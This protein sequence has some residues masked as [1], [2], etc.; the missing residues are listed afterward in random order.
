MDIGAWLRGLGLRQYEQMFREHGVDLE[1]LPYLTLDDL[2]DMGV[3]AVGH[4]RKLLQAAGP[5]RVMPDNPQMPTSAAPEQPTKLAAER[6]Q[7]TVA[8]FDLVGSTALSRRLD[9][10]DMREIIRAYQNATA[11]EI[12]RFGG[13]VAK[14]MGDGVLAYFGWPQAQEDAAERAVR[15]ALGV[16]Q[17][18][19]R[20]A[21]PVEEPLIPRI[22]IATGV[23]VV[24]DLVG[25]GAAQEEAVVGETP[26]LAARLQQVAE[27]GTVV[28]GDAT[29]RLLGDLFVVERLPSPMLRGFDDSVHAYRVLGEGGAESRFEAMHGA[30]P[31]PLIGREPEL[32]LLLERWQLATAGEGQVVLLGGE[33]GIGKSRLVLA[34]RER[35][36][37][38]NR[39]R[40]SYA[41]SPHHTNSVLWPVT[42]QLERAARFSRD[43]R[44]AE[45][46][47]KLRSLLA[48][49]AEATEEMVTLLAELLGMPGNGELPFLNLTPQVRKARTLTVLMTQLEGLAER[50]PVLLILEDSHWLDPTTRELFDLVVDRIRRL[51]VLLVVTFRPELEPPWTGFAHVT[52]LTLNRLARDQAE[53]LVTHVAGGRHLPAEVVNAILARTEGMPLF[54]EELTKTVLEAG[55]LAETADGL[56]LAGPLPSLA[57]PAS[58]NDSL[59]ARLDRLL[60]VKQVAQTAA[61][62]GRD[63]GHALLAAVAGLSARHLQDALE[64]LVRAELVF[65][66]GTSPEAT[67]SFKH[68]LVR[69][70]AYESLLRSR[71]QQLHGRIADALERQSNV[72]EVEPET[73][74]HHLTEAGLN[75]KAVEY[76]LRAGQR[77][78]GQ[79]AHKE[80]ISHLTRGLAV[81]A[82]LPATEEHARQ[83]LEMQAALASALTAIKGWA[84]P[85]VELAHE[86]AR[87]LGHELGNRPHVATA[88]RGL[89]SVFHVRAQLRRAQELA[90]ELLEIVRQ[91]AD[92]IIR[93]DAYNVK[94]YTLFHLGCFCDARDNLEAAM[95]QLKYSGELVNA[96]S[97]GVSVGVF[98]RAYAAHCDWHLGNHRRALDEA[99]GAIELARQLGQPF[100]LALALAY[101]TML[102]QFRGEPARV[103]ELAEATLAVAGEHDF[104]YYRA[105]A[106]IL[107]GWASTTDGTNAATEG[108]RRIQAGLAGIQTTGAE[109]RLP[110]YLGL[111]AELHLRAAQPDVA[112]RV[113]DDAFATAARNEERWNDANLWLIKGDAELAVAPDTQ[114]VAAIC[115]SRAIEVAHA[116]GA[117]PLVL[118]GRLRLAQLDLGQEHRTETRKLLA[119]C[120]AG[121]DQ[122]TTTPEL[123]KARTILADLAG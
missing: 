29:Q 9:P 30:T 26:N 45:R 84:A 46:V 119:G 121:F 81:L 80:A 47:A 19:G 35:L 61:C 1:V 120:V 86:R 54:T 27:P 108:I 49:A 115:Y 62:I 88:L 41:C 96:T 60:S 57:I 109:L 52:S 68:A 92:P 36:R 17:A 25:E 22:G 74:A 82:T 7:L 112:V 69:D 117:P 3:T 93:A 37:T 91:E 6:R 113:L 101:E 8:F 39:T 104:T 89:C 102:R 103:H 87:Q 107:A 5:L 32:A 43:D 31:S 10:E 90:A 79:S 15:A 99:H 40:I 66:H 98:N 23:V 58:L 95:V 75:E 106:D 55:L 24:G 42:R 110:Y 72:A 16:V 123:E 111:L 77:A 78:A 13:H 11:G 53:V 44:P 14:F 63:F 85:E 20:V 71:R 83:E 122:E 21:T 64:Q 38:E 118:R 4:R 18:L 65:Q 34:L 59:M 105:W 114:E 33:P 67:Y 116:Q 70:A 28:I 97:L 50:R 94:S 48:E 51:R 100:S 73:L 76:W 12:L 2:K 56:I